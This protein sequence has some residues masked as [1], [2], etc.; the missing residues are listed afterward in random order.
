MAMGRTAAISATTASLPH[1]LGSFLPTGTSIGVVLGPLVGLVIW[2]LPLT[3]NPAAHR[4]FAIVGFLLVYWMTETMEHGITALIGCLLFWFLQVAPPEIAFSGFTSPAAWFLF[5]ALLIGQAA[6]QTGLAKRLGYYVMARVGNSYTRLLLGFTLLVCALNLLLSPTAQIATLAPVAMGIVAA[7]GILAKQTGMHVLWSQWGLA[8]LPMFL[9]TIVVS[10]LTI[11][12]LYPADP[13]TRPPDQSALHDMVRALGPWS[14]NEQKVLGCLLLAVVLWATDFLH[15]VNPAA[16]GIGI[17]VFLTL[18]RIGVLDAKAIKSVNFLP[19]LFVG[20]ALSMANVLTDTHALA[21]LTDSLGTWHAVLLSEGWRATLTLYWGGFLYHFLVG[22]EMTMVS[23]LLPALLHVATAQGYNPVAMG[24]LWVF[25]GSGKLFVYQSTVLIL[26]YSYG[27]FTGRDLLKVGAILTVVEGLFLLI[28]VPC[29]W[30]LVGLPWKSTPASQ[31]VRSSR[32][33]E[34]VSAGQSRASHLEHRQDTRQTADP[35]AAQTPGTAFTPTTSAASDV[36]AAVRGMV[37]DTGPQDVVAAPT[38]A[39]TTIEF[40]KKLY[41][42]TWYERTKVWC[43]RRLAL[44]Q[45]S[46]L[47]PW[48]RTLCTI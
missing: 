14:R 7:W 17:G 39:K 48:R 12:W 21:G 46:A 34:P 31:V 32:R 41:A 42:V 47:S 28:L 10:W 22:S 35:P 1:K 15:H 2:G 8:F 20:G 33:A 36:A 44:Q 37:Q 26:G 25:A 30:P 6:T 43:I 16:I 5:G 24:L 23:T 11:R 40:E 3:L 27:F 13:E 29:Y 9:L 19:V 18:P 4:A 45:R 38:S